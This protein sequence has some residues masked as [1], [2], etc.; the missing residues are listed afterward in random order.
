MKGRFSREELFELNIIKKHSIGINFIP[1]S[2]AFEKYGENVTVFELL[3]T[4]NEIEELTKNLL[5]KNYTEGYIKT[6]GLVTNRFDSERVEIDF[7][8]DE[9]YEIEGLF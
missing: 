1:T 6:S 3:L 2:N 4:E 9:I 7:S 5:S 8:T